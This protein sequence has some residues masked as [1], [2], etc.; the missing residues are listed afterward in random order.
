MLGEFNESQPYCVH[1]VNAATLKELFG[2]QEASCLLGGYLTGEL[3]HSFLLLL[4]G[5]DRGLGVGGG[6]KPLLAAIIDA[7]VDPEPNGSVV[8]KFG[9]LKICSPHGSESLLLKKQYH[10]RTTYTALNLPKLDQGEVFLL[11]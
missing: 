6:C 11:C 4:E 10:F 7:K 9:D 2:L 1:D 8:F 3:S 5:L